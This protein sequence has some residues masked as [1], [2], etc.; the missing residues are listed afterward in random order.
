ML[1]PISCLFKGLGLWARNSPAGSEQICS[2]RDQARGDFTLK[3][4]L[5]IITELATGNSRTSLIDSV[6]LLLHSWWQREKNIPKG[7]KMPMWIKYN[8]G[9]EEKNK[10]PLILINC[11][12]LLSSS[13]SSSVHLESSDLPDETNRKLIL[14]YKNL[15]LSGS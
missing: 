4:V 5:L 15:C 7:I 13:Q 11:R 2:Q 10:W 3:A 12:F 9:K 1:P 6:I 8:W 14:F